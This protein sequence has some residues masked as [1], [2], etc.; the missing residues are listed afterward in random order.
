MAQRY[1]RKRKRAHLDRIAKLEFELQFQASH[2]EVS[3]KIAQE[4]GRQLSHLKSRVADWDHDVRHMLGEHSVLRLE[5]GEIF[6]DDL[7]QP[8]RVPSGPGPLRIVDLSP[9][10]PIGEIVMRIEP[11][12]HM[13]CSLS[14]PDAMTLRRYL[15][16]KFT[17]HDQYQYA[18]SESLWRDFHLGRVDQRLLIEEIGRGMLA[19]ERKREVRVA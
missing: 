16:V 7:N 10:A 6:V 1:G 2:A 5:V 14:E 19:L 9:H 8:R 4:R 13:L 3:A 17:T 18:F 15:R 12:V 11:M